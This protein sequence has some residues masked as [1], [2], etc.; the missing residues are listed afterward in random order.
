MGGEGE[1]E[2]RGAK[3]IRKAAGGVPGSSLTVKEKKVFQDSLRALKEQ[4]GRFGLFDPL[5]PESALL[6]FAEEERK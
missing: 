3:K 4:E 5:D 1:M 2:K 6:F